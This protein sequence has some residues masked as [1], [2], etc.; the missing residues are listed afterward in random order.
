LSIFDKFHAEDMSYAFVSAPCPQPNDTT[1]IFEADLWD[2][3]FT[4]YRFDQE[5][6]TVLLDQAAKDGVSRNAL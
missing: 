2:P 3:G 6:A 5:Q 4:D 1:V